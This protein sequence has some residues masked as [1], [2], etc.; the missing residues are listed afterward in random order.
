MLLHRAELFD[1][2][3]TKGLKVFDHPLDQPFRRGSAGTPIVSC[4]SSHS[5]RISV[6]S[7]S[8]CAGVP[9]IRATSTNLLEFEELSEP[10]TS[11]TSLCLARSFTASCRFCVA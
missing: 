4:P 3:R 9:S 10:I 2:G 8:R 5:G 1:G 11:T 6:S 7:S